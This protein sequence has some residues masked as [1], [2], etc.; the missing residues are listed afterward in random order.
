LDGDAKLWTVVIPASEPI[1][2][3]R[4]YQFFLDA[5]L[6]ARDGVSVFFIGATIFA[7]LICAY[8][9]YKR[10]HKRPA[11][12]IV[13][14][15]LGATLVGIP[16]YL[17]EG[18]TWNNLVIIAICCTPFAGLLV[19]LLFQRREQTK[20]S[21]PLAVIS[22]CVLCW[23]VLSFALSN[24]Q[25]ATAADVEHLESAKS[26]AEDL[27]KTHPHEKVYH[28]LFPDLFFACPASIYHSQY[29]LGDLTWAEPRYTIGVP[30]DED[31][32]TRYAAFVNSPHFGLPSWLKAHYRP[33]WSTRIIVGE[34]YL[35]YDHVSLT[36][37]ERTSS[38]QHRER[39]VDVSYHGRKAQRVELNPTNGPS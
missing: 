5:F 19:A 22:T 6:G 16:A 10:G 39:R 26:F 38:A 20:M 32:H 36:F 3:W 31:P 1:F 7:S 28:T 9:A 14:S 18:G 37:Y 33:I 25:V 2:W 15:A 34:W 8:I 23:M 30:L 12:V 29:A 21:H 35:Q 11:I 17:K 24:Q 27:C 4:G 13:G